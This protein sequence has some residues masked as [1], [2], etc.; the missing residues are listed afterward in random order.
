MSAPTEQTQTP[1][2][3]TVTDDGGDTTAAEAVETPAQP[4]DVS[5][6]KP[7]A[8]SSLERTRY[9]APRYPRAAQ[10]RGESGWVDI[11]FTVALDGTVK[12][13]VVRDSQPDGVFDKAAIRAVEK[14][15]FEPVIEDGRAVEKRAGVRM[16]FALE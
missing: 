6:Q 13:V 3:E 10:R 9:V 14:W 12:D 8:I 2:E 1:A 5:Q 7:V 4:V 16:M 15:A 11:V